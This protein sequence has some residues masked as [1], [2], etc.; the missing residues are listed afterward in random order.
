M[1]RTLT[2][3]DYCSL[4]IVLQSCMN[5]ERVQDLLDR[6]STCVQR[7]GAAW[8]IVSLV[9]HLKFTLSPSVLIYE[10]GSMLAAA[11]SRLAV[12]FLV[13]DDAMRS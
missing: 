11:K 2:L 9:Y 4:S 7:L 12:K 10:L 1:I 13:T 5:G 8:A 3:P 6:L